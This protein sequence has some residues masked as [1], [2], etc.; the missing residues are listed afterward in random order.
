MKS[1]CLAFFLALFC[2][3]LVNGCHSHPFAMNHAPRVIYLPRH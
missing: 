2:L 3:W 1:L